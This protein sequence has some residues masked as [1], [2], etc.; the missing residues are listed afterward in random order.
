MIDVAVAWFAELKGLFYN[1]IGYAYL[2]LADLL[3]MGVLV[4]MV[5][6]LI[7]RFTTGRQIFGFNKNVVL[8]PKASFGIKRDSTIVGVFILFHV[9]SRYLGSTRRDGAGGWQPVAALCDAGQQP[10]GGY[11][12]R[13]VGS[14]GARLLLGCHRL[15]HAVH[16][17]LPDLEAHPPGDGAGELCA[18]ARAP[19]D[20]RTRQDQ[21]RGREPH[22]VRRVEVGASL[23]R[24]Q[25]LDAYACIMCNRCQDVC[26]AN[27]TG[28]VLSPSALEINKRYQINQE[29]KALAAGKESSTPLI[30]F[31]ISP[32]AVW[33]CTSCGACIE[34]CPVG[35]EPMRDILDIRRSL[36]LMDNQFPTQLQQAFKGMERTGNP[37]NIAPESRLDWAKG[38][39]RPD[40]RAESRAGYFVVGGLRA[41]YRC[42]RAEDGAGLCQGAQRGGRELC[43]AGQDG[44]LHGRLGA[45]RG[46]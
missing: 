7:R 38:L 20:G 44:T 19:I 23:P 37:W 43:R 24:P 21:L 12:D 5:A 9:G 42:A 8:H 11:A 6:L 39:Q 3:T 40:D 26:P 4:G 25:L 29:G 18:E 31:A 10:V 22:A 32:E 41:G 16:P 34:V 27:H 1:P 14:V 17:V 36:V 15:D 13:D 45:A 46:Q 2:L 35:N 33:A 28:K 30:E